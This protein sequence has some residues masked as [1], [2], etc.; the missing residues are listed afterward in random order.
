MVCG[1]LVAAAVLAA[2]LALRIGDYPLTLAQVAGSL[3]GQED[4]FAATVVVEWRLP[5]AFGALIFGAALGVSGA[6][7]QSLTRNP[8]GSPDI[9][10]FTT[11]SYTGALIV[12][13]FAGGGFY[14]IATG[15]LVG[16][17]LTAVAVYAFAYRR[18]VTS[19]RL[20]IVGIGMTAMLNAFNT[21]LLMRAEREVALAGA[22]W[23][24]GSVSGLAWSQVAPVSA[25]LLAAF[26]LAALVSRPM[27]ASE[28][29]DDAASALGVNVER[30]RL[31]VVVVAV[32]LTALVTAVAGP[33]A[34]V[35]LAAPQL[36]RRLTG[37]AGVT[38][39]ASAAMGALLLSVSDLIAQN[40]LANLPVGVVTVSVGGLYL[41]WLLVMETRRRSVRR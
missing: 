34:F 37:S 17:L 29:G 25:L 9:I 40:L 35:A 18:G 13:I 30:T 22:T 7:F 2:M 19:F 20:I 39:A 28:L 26:A 33:I 3:L 12:I 31:A 14:A 4:G 16:G 32:A 23:G 5:R 1:V 41:V 36:A 8:L 15:S 21:Y 10:G 24:A 6:M 11:G 27:R 38:L